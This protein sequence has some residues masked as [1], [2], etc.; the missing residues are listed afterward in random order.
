MQSPDQ[1]VERNR[2]LLLDRSLVGLKKYGVTTER[3][4]LTLNEWLQ[5]LLEELL[6]A[7]NYVQAAMNNAAPDTFAQ[8]FSMYEG[9]LLWILYHHQGGKSTIGQPI[10]RL[11]GIKQ[12]A[13]LSAMQVQHAEAVARMYGS[14]NNLHAEPSATDTT[15]PTLCQTIHLGQPGVT[16]EPC[17]MLG[18]DEEE[19]A[20]LLFT[21]P[22]TEVRL[23]WPTQTQALAVLA[24]ATGEQAET[25]PAHAPVE[26]ATHKKSLSVRQ[27][28]ID[29]LLST[30]GQSE[31]VAADA[32]MSIMRPPVERVEQGHD[33]I[34]LDKARKI[35]QIMYGDM[36]KGGSTQLL[37]M[38]Q[39]C[40]LEAM[41]HV[42]T[43][44]HAPTPV[45]LAAK[46]QGMCISAQGLLARVRGRLQF[47]ARE[48]LKH[49]EEM[50]DRYYAGDISVV[51]E[52][53]QLYCLDEK[54]PEQQTEGAQR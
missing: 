32:I 11:L 28:I 8:R 3:D 46:H 20:C 27:S 25:P 35:I 10:R 16:V 15:P 1:N 49:L 36:P 5:H 50:A 26:Q 37:A 45:P 29:V 38:V 51:D 12:H 6:D 17:L 21:A 52:F 24:A 53:L 34:A 9:M 33:A 31:A 4:D 19:V 7:A 13:P 23:T 44:Q 40:V 41:S 18:P 48:M 2:Q 43:P 47:G 39:V 30:T 14:P 22:G 42:C 54:R